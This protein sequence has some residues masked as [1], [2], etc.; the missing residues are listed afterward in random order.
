MQ[1][2]K[3]AMDIRTS[4]TGIADDTSL[5]LTEKYRLLHMETVFLCKNLL[6]DECIYSN[7]LHDLAEI[8]FKNSLIKEHTRTFFHCMKIDTENVMDMLT[9][10]DE[11]LFR[12]SAITIE[13]LAV[14]KDTEEE[15]T[16]YI[17]LWRK[18]YAG[19]E[20]GKKIK[21]IRCTFTGYKD[22]YISV[23]PNNDPLL[24]EINVS[25]Q[26]YD[27]DYTFRESIIYL[28]KGMKLNLV[29][30]IWDG[31]ILKADIIVIEPDY[32]MDISTV[33]DCV[34][35]YGTHPANYYYRLLKPA[36][37]QKALIL[38]NIV[39]QFL[40]EWIYSIT[41]PEYMN[42]MKKVFKRYSMELIT[43]P[44]IDTDER[45]FFNTCYFHFENLRKTVKCIFPDKR[46]A[47]DADD[48][49]L[50]PSYICETLGLQGRLD[51]MQ[52]DISSF[53][54]MKSGKAD[55]F[56]RRGSIE[57]LLSNKVQMM[58]YLATLQYTL[59]ICHQNIRAFLLY[60]KYPELYSSTPSWD[61]VRK[62]INTRNRIVAYEYLLQKNNTPEFTAKIISKISPETINENLTGGKLWTD[63]IEPGIRHFSKKLANLD[64][65]QRAY[66]LSLFTFISKELYLSKTGNGEPD[67]NNSSSVWEMTLSEKEKKGLIIKDMKILKNRISDIH[68]PYII[69]SKPEPE[70]DSI[71]NFRN[72]DPVIV[73]ERNTGADKA[74]NKMIFKG[75][76]EDISNT[77]I[78]IRFR[79]PQ[80]N[81]KV[82][83]ENSMFAAEP[84]Y[85]DKPTLS[86]F[87]CLDSLTDANSDRIGLI[88]GT[89]EP[90]FDET[91]LKDAEIIEDDFQRIA[92]KSLAA[93]DMML[94]IGP[95]GSG[96]TSIALKKIVEKHLENGTDN[97]LLLSYTNRA[98][99]EIC[100]SISGIVPK[101]DFIRL[102]NELVCERKYR[103][104]LIENRLKECS[105]RSEAREIIRKCRIF[106]STVVTLQNRP[107]IFRLKKFGCAIIDE[108]TQILEPQIIGILTAKFS[109][110]ENAVKKIIMIGDNK[111]LPAVTLQSE[112]D[113]KIK[114]E[115]LQNA[116]F[117]SFKE[118]LF[119]RLF[120]IYNEKK[121]TCVDMLCKQGRMHKDIADFTSRYFY[122]NRL[123]PV[124]LDH[125]T[126]E[127]EQ[128]Y[129]SSGND[130]DNII[131]LRMAFIPSSSDKN[132]YNDKTNI[133]EAKIAAS[134]AYSIYIKNKDYFDPEKTI[135]IIAPYRNQIS[136]IRQELAKTGIEALLRIT[137]DT[138]ERYQGSERDYIIFTFCLNK[139]Y[140]IKMM[141]NIIYENGVAIDR[142]LNV[143][144][145]RARKHLF[146]TGN[147][148][149][150]KENNIYSKL[151]SY[152]KKH[153]LYI[154]KG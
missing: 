112:D 94:I 4:I 90:E 32:L 3:N 92:M 55:E 63:Y 54:E 53:I 130:Y 152:M 33:A 72:G 144:L 28:K 24:K 58:L 122:F 31:N 102:G 118:S 47:I 82:I 154:N 89:R 21:R 52:R 50:E 10:P 1:I 79:S 134:L 93:K 146:I 113:A 16:A 108:S 34:K 11:R 13:K 38:G 110:G 78:R 84:D 151:I 15:I 64:E 136:L 123:V 120:R 59:D 133:E 44:E 98:V 106:V 142:K 115:I 56:T 14:N 135:G 80:R 121:H 17:Q 42:T 143:A 126:E 148:E 141:A 73:Y 83:N 25:V 125:Q 61:M 153:N 30:C 100:K 65:K 20:K 87:R 86:M 66:Y 43:C 9:S 145:T 68:A 75:Y 22:N 48:A 29:D 140:Q 2:S 119:E 35:E 128:T 39:N 99:D 77:D 60:T 19:L 97:I 40:D 26:K 91:L 69:F 131:K 124:G 96:K 149:I 88:M 8:L 49:V 103:S 116:G 139:S 5:D 27:G 71:L 57:A 74:T 150:M 95:P 109:D 7:D 46:Y 62:A 105:R 18:K 70:N 6:H 76:I 36:G 147:E 23:I 138:V 12:Y 37:P 45:D 67:R 81:P 114:S 111:Q 117:C 129:I 132:N 127:D 107:E 85:N 137:I 101:T 104:H 51:Y 41:E